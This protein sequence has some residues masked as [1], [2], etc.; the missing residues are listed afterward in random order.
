MAIT[1]PAR[2]PTAQDRAASTLRRA[3]LDGELRPGQRVN[4]EAWAERARVSPI[5]LR[6]ALRALAGEGLVTYRPRRGYAVTE[7][8]L[9]ELEEVYRLRKMLET[10]A[11]RR[12]VPRATRADVASLEAA[13]EACRASA[14]SGDVAGQL[15]ANRRFHDRLHALAE[16]RPAT[17]LIDLLWDSTEAY[18]A[19]YYALPGEAAAA[20]RA[21]R[22]IIAAVRAGD[23]ERVIALQDQHRARALERL[24]TSFRGEADTSPEAALSV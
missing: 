12:G 3:I 10:D 17:R 24:R 6:E 11:L 20:D 21:H 23:P 4:Q 13:A 9:A 14:A 8:D 19:L 22:T 7:L 2:A 15:A 1:V 5:P 16:S 18:R